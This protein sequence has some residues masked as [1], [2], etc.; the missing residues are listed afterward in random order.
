MRSPHS[1]GLRH[2][3]DQPVQE[4]RLEDAGLGGAVGAGA[5]PLL[6]VATNWLGVTD[7]AR[8]FEE[9]AAFLS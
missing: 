7:I 2:V 1:S 6:L 5:R 9:V 8:T 4:V 3:A